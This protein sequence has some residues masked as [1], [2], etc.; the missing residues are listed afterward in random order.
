MHRERPDAAL[1]VFDTLLVRDGHLQ[2]PEAHLERLG[3]STRELYGRG[4]PA[5][6]HASIFRRAGELRGTHRLRIDVIPGPSELDVEI[7]TSEGDPGEP[8]PVVCRPVPVSG[9]LGAHKWRDRRL[10]DALAEPDRVP[11]L[12]DDDGAVLEAASANV[13][14]IERGRLVT[15]PTDGRILA[16]VTRALLLALA[17]LN[18]LDA[19]VEP[20]SL[21]RA[22]EANAIFLTSAIRLAVGAGLEPSSRDAPGEAPGDAPAGAGAPTAIATIRGL[23]SAT[24]WA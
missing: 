5:D 2:A 11:L 3:R 21:A 16:G 18:G 15:P 17:P 1:G 19:V 10:L 23:L 14:L 12:I 6:L 13:W 7:H 20:I 8:S 4:L 22:A 9:G 24:S